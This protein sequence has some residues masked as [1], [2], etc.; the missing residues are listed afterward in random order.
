[1]EMEKQ[2]HIEDS[3]H[4]LAAVGPRTKLDTGDVVY[5]DTMTSALEQ[6]NIR[7]GVGMFLGMQAVT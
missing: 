1:M 4:R 5:T 3:C 7:T 6:N 2:I